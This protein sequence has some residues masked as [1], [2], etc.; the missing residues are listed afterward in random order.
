MALEQLTVPFTETSDGVTWHYG[1][2]HKTISVLQRNGVWYVA[3]GG[4]YPHAKNKWVIFPQVLQDAL[5]GTREWF[6]VSLEWAHGDI[7]LGGWR[8]DKVYVVDTP[9]LVTEKVILNEPAIG[10]VIMWVHQYPHGDK[11]YRYVATRVDDGTWYV[12]GQDGATTWK[13]L[14]EKYTALND[15]Q[16]EYLS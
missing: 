2:L 5:D 3:P 9:V 11:V 7:F 16:Y 12:T 13:I 8:V 10:S 4:T 6:C 15:G 14:S 1:D